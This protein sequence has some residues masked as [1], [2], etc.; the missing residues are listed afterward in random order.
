MEEA[1]RERSKPFKP[2]ELDGQ[3]RVVYSE[4]KQRYGAPRIADELKDRGLR[5]SEN[6]VA[7][8]M[9]KL[10]LQGVQAKP[11]KRTT[12]SHHDKPVAPDLIQ[13]DFTAKAANQKWV[14]DVT[15]LWTDEGWLYGSTDECERII[16]RIKEPQ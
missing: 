8:R 2:G 11:F 6:R 9:Q 10:G 3:I 16:G 1:P 12:D 14:S 7:R 5:C 15:Y 13:Q 4:H